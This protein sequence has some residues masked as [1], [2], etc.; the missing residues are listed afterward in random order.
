MAVENTVPANQ[1]AN[2]I[3]IDENEYL[4]TLSSNLSILQYCDDAQLLLLP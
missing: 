3:A 4:Y 2:V 1:P